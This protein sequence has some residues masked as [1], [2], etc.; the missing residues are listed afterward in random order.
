MFAHVRTPAC[1]IVILA[2]FIFLCG[3]VSSSIG[4]VGYSGDKITA[5]ITNPDEP[6]DAF[7]QVT[8]Y[9]VTGLSQQ[10]HTVIMAGVKLETGDNTVLIPAPLA[11]GNYKLKMYL[12][13][14]DERKT[15]VIR[16]IVV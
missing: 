15:A 4:E 16:D 12:I 13:Q 1:G 8:I 11:P 3:C 9:R 7:V 2:L 10:E 14:N 5:N 6:S